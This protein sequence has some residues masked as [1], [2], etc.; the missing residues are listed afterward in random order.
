MLMDVLCVC[1]VV[2]WTYVFWGFVMYLRFIYYQKLLVYVLYY[3]LGWC[4]KPYYDACGCVLCDSCASII[5]IIIIVQS[6]NFWGTLT[7]VCR[8]CKP[9]SY[10]TL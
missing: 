10:G 7:I 6:I 4:P 9:Q 3:D 2:Y 5:F 1:T 8:V